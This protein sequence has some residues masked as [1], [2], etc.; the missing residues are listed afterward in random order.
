MFVNQ[1]TRIRSGRFIRVVACLAAVT[2]ITFTHHTMA[3]AGTTIDRPNSE[4]VSVNRSKTVRTPS[5]VRLKPAKAARRKIS[6]NIR[7]TPQAAPSLRADIGFIP[8]VHGF[9]FANWSASTE[10]DD[11]NL[12]IARR[13]FGDSSVCAQMDD[14]NCIPYAGVDAFLERLNTELDKGRCE[15][16]VLLAFQRMREGS[17]GTQALTTDE[18]IDDLNYWSATQI[19]PAAKSRAR[20]SRGWDVA[21]IVAAIHDDLMRGGGAV[22]GL[23]TG[24]YAHSVLPI[25]IEIAK[26]S[27]NIRLYD[28]NYPLVSQKMVVDLAS[29]AWSYTPVDTRGN[30]SAAWAGSATGGLSLV[31][32]STRAPVEVANFKP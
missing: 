23:Y 11:A 26:T 22:L 7:R 6:S 24:G 3:F 5:K 16:L 25:S 8:D 30:A 12:A 1:S 2:G 4:R 29:G 27:A 20:E 9:S 31:P 28:P 10:S 19:L 13:L 18:V 14:L 15:G 17:T 21:R 32:L